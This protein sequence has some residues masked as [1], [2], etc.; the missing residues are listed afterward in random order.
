MV[1][2]KESKVSN[3]KITLPSVDTRV[4]QK[5]MEYKKDTPKAAIQTEVSS[6]THIIN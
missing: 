3:Q 1:E 4:E 5:F 6:G 2:I